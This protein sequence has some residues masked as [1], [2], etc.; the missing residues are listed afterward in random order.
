MTI[1]NLFEGGSLSTETQKAIEES[2]NAAMAVKEAALTEAF[3]QKEMQLEAE[4]ASKVVELVESAVADEMN[5]LV[6]EIKHARTLEIQYAEKLQ[7]F[8]ESYDESQQEHA[9]TIIA[10]T[11]AEEL[12]AIQEEVEM[13][14]KY[15]FVMSM[16]ESFKDSYAKLFG[17][18][19]ISIVD[20]LSEAEAELETLRKEK[21]L[22]EILESVSGEKRAVVATI[23]ESVPVHKMDE[24]F[25][26]IRPALLNESAI[27]APA[28]KKTATNGSRVVM[29]NYT[30]EPTGNTEVVDPLVEKLNR[31]LKL[32]LGR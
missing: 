20:R 2:F 28:P 8:K 25:N 1:K 7:A 30:A 24:K 10:E 9:K 27:A 22:N 31:S 6:D 18:A 32:A 3:K 26:S 17:G 4:M 5:D 15:Q 19:D 23:L 29:E 14:K 12:M 16:F 11:I 21:K 13:V